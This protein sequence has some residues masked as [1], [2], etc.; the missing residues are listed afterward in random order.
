MNYCRIPFLLI[1]IWRDKMEK[2]E[3][4]ICE[5][6]LPEKLPKFC[7]RC[8]WELHNDLSLNLS[9]DLPDNVLEDYGDR[10]LNARK[11]WQ[12]RIEAVREKENLEKKLEN[13]EK[14]LAV[15]EK[16]QQKIEELE[17]RLETPEKKRC[18]KDEDGNYSINSMSFTKLDKH[19][20]ELPDSAKTWAMVKDNNTGL[21]WEVKTNDGSIHDRDKKY[22]WYDAKDVFIKKLNR[23]KFGGFSDW[24]LPTIKELGTIVHYGQYDP[25]ID[26]KYFPKTV[27]SFYWSSTT[28][29]VDTY[30]AWGV[31]FNDG[32]DYYNDKSSG[33]YVRAVRGGQGG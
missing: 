29:A 22:S 24:R 15:I 2:K 27:S 3:C 13:M 18:E 8:G 7:N 26:T 25:A 11:H 14:W 20:N 4:P 1:I 6:S 33:Y 5:N 31:D 12:E 28:Y 17:K 32:L 21:I 10:V 19:G 23:Q 30:N 16:K 9:L